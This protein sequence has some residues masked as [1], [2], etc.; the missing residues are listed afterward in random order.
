MPP[1][2]S[3]VRGFA[4]LPGRD[5]GQFSWWGPASPAGGGRNGDYRTS[6]T[7]HGT[8]SDQTVSPL[9]LPTT[10]SGRGTKRTRFSVCNGR[11]DAVPFQRRNLRC[12]AST[13]TIPHP[14]LSARPA[15]I[16][17]RSRPRVCLVRHSP[18]TDIHGL[19]RR[20]VPRPG[21]RRGRCGDWLHCGS[22]S[23]VRG[24]PARHG[25]TWRSDRRAR[26]ADGCGERT[27][28]RSVPNGADGGGGGDQANISGGN[29][30]PAE[31]KTSVA[32]LKREV[33]LIWACLS[34]WFR[35]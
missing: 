25:R 23:R 1:R 10:D 13:R 20:P 11:D 29:A 26:G 12:P 6:L 28:F 15:R 17:R 4:L 35:Q 2:Q 33:R 5:V 14:P 30:D 16:G 31:V 32:V 24:W 34:C 8:S 27:A 22:G 9:R 3:A 7:A 19:G 21:G 18:I